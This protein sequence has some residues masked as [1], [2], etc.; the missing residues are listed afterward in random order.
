MNRSPC[1]TMS[2]W[3]AE[4]ACKSCWPTR[5]MSRL[6]GAWAAAGVTTNASRSRSA[7]RRMLM[8]GNCSVAAGAEPCRRA[9]SA[10]RGEGGDGAAS[11]GVD[12]V[13]HD[14]AAVPLDLVPH[15]VV[16][17]GLGDQPLPEIA[18]RHGLLAGAQ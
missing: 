1:L 7:I 9:R 16:P 5:R 4:R 12:A 15:D 3:Y 11:E 8:A 2:G 17:P 14:V 6:S 18:V 13:V 10:A